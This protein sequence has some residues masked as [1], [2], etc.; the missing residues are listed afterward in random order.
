MQHVK[1]TLGFSLMCVC[2]Q[3]ND[4]PESAV[5]KLFAS[6]RKN[7]TQLTEYGAC[8]QCLQAMPSEPQMRVRAR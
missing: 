4:G 1:Y 5:T 2:L 6:A 3:E 8:T 7:G